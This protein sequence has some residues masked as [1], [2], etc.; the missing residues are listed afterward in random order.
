MAELRGHW[1]YSL[2]SWRLTVG[3]ASMRPYLFVEWPLSE[4]RRIMA[5]RPGQDFSY[6]NKLP[7][8]FSQDSPVCD[9]LE[10]LTCQL[11]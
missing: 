2:P 1:I 7:L 11:Y 3:V 8:C 9:L 10:T 4:S 6:D 5:H